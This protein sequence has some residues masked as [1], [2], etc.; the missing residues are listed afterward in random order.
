MHS[1]TLSLGLSDAFCLAAG[2]DLSPRGIR[3][4]KEGSYAAHR[5]Q[6]ECASLSESEN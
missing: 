3:V 1:A 4:R 6:A 2:W 5:I